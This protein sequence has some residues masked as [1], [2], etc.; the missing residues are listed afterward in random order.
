MEK[1]KNIINIMVVYYFLEN[2]S[3]GERKEGKEYNCDGKL[4]Y[5][6]EFL[7]GKKMEME[8]YMISKIIIIK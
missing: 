8:N 7:Y 4:I 5:E 3:N 2:I 6:G 1:S